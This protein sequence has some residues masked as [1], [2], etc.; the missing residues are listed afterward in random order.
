MKGGRQ[1]HCKIPGDSDHKGCLDDDLDFYSATLQRDVKLNTLD[2]SYFSLR[3]VLG[4]WEFF[5]LLL[6]LCI[7]Q[8]IERFIILQTADRIYSKHGQTLAADS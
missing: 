3:K 7:I 5:L 1:L 6:L 4:S 8:R 2:T